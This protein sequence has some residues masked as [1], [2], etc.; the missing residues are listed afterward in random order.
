M[1]VAEKFAGEL[2]I[3]L[4]LG[5]CRFLGGVEGAAVGLYHLAVCPVDDEGIG[6]VAVRV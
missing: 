1:P 6:V 4:F 3:L 5:E 2:V